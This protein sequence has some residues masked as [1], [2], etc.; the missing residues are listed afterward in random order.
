MSTRLLLA[1][2]DPALRRVLTRRLED[3]GYSV[4]PIDALDGLPE[5]LG[6]SGADVVVAGVGCRSETLA[7]VREH[8][9]VLIVTLLPPETPLTDA[10]DVLDAG[11]DD[12]VIKPFSPRELVSRLQSLLR[13]APT[14]GATT[15]HRF[16]FDGLAIDTGSREVTARG[17][18]FTLPAKEFD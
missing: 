11:A 18:T 7:R 15:P 16:E 8:S 10:L 2:P 1:E 3:E 17:N 14:A 5:A 12:F 4:R 9:P 6:E 13:R